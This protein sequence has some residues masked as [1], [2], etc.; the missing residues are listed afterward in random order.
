[1][2][3][4]E[5]HDGVLRIVIDDPERRNPMSNEVMRD[6]RE[7]IEQGG[8]DGAVRVLVLTGAGDR[9]FSAG[10]DL[11]GGF[12]DAPLVGHAS[13][14]ELADLFRTMM[15]TAKPIIA[16]VNGVALGGGFGLAVA[17]D[18]T[19]AADHVRMG[20][21]EVDLGLWPMMIS[22]VLIRSMPRKALL[23]MMMT[24]RIL[25]AREAADLGLVTKVV[26]KDDLDRAVDEIV[27]RLMASSPAAIALGKRA[28]YATADMDVDSS[29]DLLHLGLTAAALTEDGSE[30][31]AAFTEKRSPVWKGR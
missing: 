6:L 23:E 27:E 15:R 8:R 2:V 19:V 30:G 26:P 7:A 18:I 25:D 9:A 29:L 20:T 11:A 12:V 28:F 24:G 21:P 17:S 31:V 3:T 22:S 1:M 16:R 13:R 4:V 14:G 5:S 10:G